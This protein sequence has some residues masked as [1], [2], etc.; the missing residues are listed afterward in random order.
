[1][2]FHPTDNNTYW[3]GAPAGGLWQTT[4]DGN[5]WT[6]LTD[7]NPIQGVSDIVIPSDFDT[8]HTIYIATGD[9]DGN[10][11]RSIGVLKTTD[12]GTTWQATDLSFTFEQNAMVN[13]LLLDP[14]DNNTIIAA[15]NK[16]VYK[17]TD[18]GNTWSDKLSN[19][20]FIDMEYK[21]GDFNVLYGSS[22]GGGSMS[23]ST[24]GG[25]TWNHYNF[26]GKRVE[27]AVTPAND[28]Y[29]YALV[30]GSSNGLHGVYLS[31][32][33]GLTFNQVLSGGDMN[34]LG[35]YDGSGAG[36]QGWYD[37]SLAASPIDEDVVYVGGV[38]TWKSTNGGVS[39]S[40]NNH[41]IGQGA[42]AVHADKHNLK[43]R[44]NGDLF[45]CNDGGIYIKRDGNTLWEDRTNGMMISQMYK[46]SVSATVA[47]EVITGLQDNGTKLFSNNAWDD[48]KGGDGMECLIDYTDANIQYGTYVYGQISRTTNHWASTQD[49]EPYNAGQGAWVTPYI[50]DPVDHNTLYAGYADVWKTTNKGN[51]WTKIST[52]NVSSKIR[53][54]AIS[55]SNNQVICVAAQSGIWR[56]TDG[57]NTWSSIVGGLPINGSNIT[58]IAIKADDP[59]TIWVTLSA[60]NDKTVYQTTDGGSTWAN[61]SAGLPPIPAY[62]IVQNRQSVSETHLYVGT[63]L[64]IFYK[65]GEDDWIE[66][67]QGLPKVKVGELEIYYDDGNV[68]N[69]QLYVASYGRGLWK[70]PLEAPSILNP[71][72]LTKAA[73]NIGMDA[74]TLHAEVTY[75]GADAVTERGFVWSTTPNPGMSDNKLIDTQAGSGEY[76]IALDNIQPGETY[77]FRAYATNTH[78]T[79][80]GAEKSFRTT[81]AA[82]QLPFEEG[83]EGSML[84]PECWASFTGTNGLG[85]N[86]NWK[87]SAAHYE[88]SFSAF[89]APENVSGG[90]AEDWLVT[91]MLHIGPKTKLSFYQ[92]QMSASVKG[93]QYAVLVSTSSQQDIDTFV[94]LESWGEDDFSTLFSQK[95]IDLSSYEGQTICI[96]FRLTN[97]NDDGWYLDKIEIDEALSITE[98]SA[99]DKFILYP[100][101]AKDRLHI[102]FATDVS[103]GDIDISILNMLG[104][105]QIKRSVTSDKQQAII[106][107]KGLAPGAYVV[108]IKTNAWEANHKLLIE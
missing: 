79:S 18:G 37:L 105:T 72:V 60:Y 10:D 75:E 25:N 91:P 19:S 101:P 76:S 34:L 28:N 103:E 73:N 40:L 3:I 77:Y 33:Q 90:L 88:G 20:A 5:T 61:I 65:K 42:Q 59:N 71:V 15:T 17:T 22:K 81:C 23:V 97:D 64:G 86:N 47:G 69:S 6:C 95:I 35:W 66:Y 36:G 49:I 99:E 43:Y 78:G 44:S 7:Q 92:K 12:G 50:I 83:F 106:D 108:H 31:Q 82:Q 58:Y 21:P 56:T 89:V 53:S 27:L 80:L 1:M 38:N 68:D 98:T 104:Q 52:L 11:N 9:R 45:E 51:S 96:A 46:L 63:E 39:W 32:D 55:A 13:R 85:S 24:D 29:V 48:V 102:N 54:M 93:S 107:L 8:S 2:A 62:S 57:G 4:D 16:G 41:W 30:A 26:G 94:E 70:S 87:K 100:N 67:N 74:A 14:N 84:P